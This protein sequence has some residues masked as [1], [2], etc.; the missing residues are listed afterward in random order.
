MERAR[1]LFDYA[2]VCVV[3]TG[4]L[5][6]RNTRATVTHVTRFRAL[7]YI[8]HR[9]RCRAA[10][11]ISMTYARLRNERGRKGTCRENTF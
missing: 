5:F 3:I 10:N 4:G 9:G 1:N 2:P 6:A 8:I 7:N 11:D